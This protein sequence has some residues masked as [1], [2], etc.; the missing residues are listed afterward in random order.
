MPIWNIWDEDDLQQNTLKIKC[1]S[2]LGSL[3]LGNN[4]VS[5]LLIRGNERVQGDKNVFLL[6]GMK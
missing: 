5:I 1:R 2:M 3:L 4:S 6:I